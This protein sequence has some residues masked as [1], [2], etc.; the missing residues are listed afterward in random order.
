LVAQASDAQEFYFDKY[1]L[2]SRWVSLFRSKKLF[3]SCYNIL[4]LETTQSNK[5]GIAVFKHFH[6]RNA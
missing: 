5:N 2:K 4:T 6:V 1:S 3:P